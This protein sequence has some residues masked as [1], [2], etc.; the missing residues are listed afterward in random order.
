MFEITI[1]FLSFPALSGRCRF[2]TKIIYVYSDIIS[3][4]TQYNF[5]NPPDVPT[6][7]YR[8]NSPKLGSALGFV[9]HVC[10]NPQE[11]NLI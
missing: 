3:D 11:L 7:D 4:D 6:P 5:A 10:D 8:Y 1:V 2:A 9:S